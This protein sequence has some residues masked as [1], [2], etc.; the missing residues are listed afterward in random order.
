MPLIWLS[1][2]ILLFLSVLVLFRINVA[3]DLAHSWNPVAELGA[4]FSGPESFDGFY[5]PHVVL[6][7]WNY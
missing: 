3:C 1:F 7:L 6:L 4:A 2:F 5:G